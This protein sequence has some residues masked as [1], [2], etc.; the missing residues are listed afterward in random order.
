MRETTNVLLV[1]VGGQGTILASKILSTGLL[2]AGFEVKMA[3]IHG[4]SQRGGA[5]ST[6]VRFGERVFSPIIGRGEADI[7]VS[8][9]AMETL[10]WLE[11]LK[12]GGVVVAN[13]YRIPSA[14]VLSGATPYPLDPIGEV[15]A[16]AE[17]TVM[18]AAG[19]AER[20]GNSR[21]MN[22]V[23]LGA[24][25]AALQKSGA[26]P[27][28]DWKAVIAGCVKPAFVALNLAAFEAGSAVLGAAAVRASA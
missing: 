22:V 25:V 5:V 3:E 9:E 28:I 16:K 10:R 11:F 14:P 8:F 2:A 21:A 7:M 24:L 27:V 6:Q 20:L 18:D 12:P 26:L 19:I 17:T 23:L 4:M 1:G 15:A 13:D